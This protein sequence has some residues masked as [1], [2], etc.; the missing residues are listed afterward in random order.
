MPLSD[1]FDEFPT[2]KRQIGHSNIT[3]FDTHHRRVQFILVNRIGL[4]DPT[5]Y[6]VGLVAQKLPVCSMIQLQ[7]SNLWDNMENKQENVEN[8]K[9]FVIFDYFKFFTNSLL[10]LGLIR[11]LQCVT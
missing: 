8:Y 6:K 4:Q 3:Y 10:P 2:P 7:N 1:L 9:Y 11:G 5:H